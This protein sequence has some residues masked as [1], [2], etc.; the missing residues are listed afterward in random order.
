MSCVDWHWDKQSEDTIQTHISERR[1]RKQAVKRRR[2]LAVSFTPPFPL[3]HLSLCPP[4]LHMCET[5][6]RGN[7][8]QRRVFIR[9]GEAVFG[10]SLLLPAFWNRIKR[11]GKREREEWEKWKLIIFLHVLPFISLHMYLSV[12]ISFLSQVVTRF[13]LSHFD[14]KHQDEGESLIYSKTCVRGIR[15]AQTHSNLLY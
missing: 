4:S 15:Y 13:S 2:E 10:R 1:A 11:V 6:C 7:G 5:C 12:L 9:G 8:L 14:N 3:L